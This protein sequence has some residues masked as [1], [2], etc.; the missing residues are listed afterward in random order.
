VGEFTTPYLTMN[1]LFKR[2]ILLEIN[3]VTDLEHFLIS[4]KIFNF[5]KKFHQ[6][7]YEII[8]KKIDETQNLNFKQ[9]KPWL[10]N[11]IK[12]PE[13]IYNPKFLWCMGWDN[14]EIEKFI[15]N[16]Q[17]NNSKKLSQLKKDNPKGYSALTSNQIG[18][19]IKKGY[20]LE[21]SKIKVSERQ[22]TFSKEKCIIKYGE[23]KGLKKFKERQI[24]W[25]NALKNREDYTEL[26]NKKN[27]YKYSNKTTIEILQHSSFIET[28]K[29]KILENL[30]DNLDQ[31]TESILNSIE[32]KRFSELQPYINSKIIQQHFNVTKEELK[33]TFIKKL[34]FNPFDSK[35]GT[36]IY[37]KNNRFKSLKEYSLAIFLES[38]NVDYLYEINY[39]NSNKKCDFYIPNKNLFI[40]YFGMLDGKKVIKEN[41]IFEF[42]KNKM[43]EKINFCLK[44]N[45]KLIYEKD[46]DKL[47]EKL[48]TYL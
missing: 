33:N 41:S 2:K 26:Q 15:S 17:K 35:Y 21:E 27:P 3:N 44:N 14:N 6:E 20:S 24:K 42:Y 32:L 22:N 8:Q 45:I 31:F 48:N 30:N 1:I 34:K 47:I 46:Y 13:S 28:T 12:Y 9:V 7:F 38:K 10:R 37:H 11:I 43:E 23:E 36:F 29:N 19:W 25:I 5:F 4:N 16:K 18:F 39:P 40:E